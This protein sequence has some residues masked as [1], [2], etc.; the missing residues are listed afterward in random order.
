MDWSAVVAVVE[1]SFAA[2]E[3]VACVVDVVSGV[4]AAV[5]CTAGNFVVV[6]VVVA[7]FAVVADVVVVHPVVVVA[8]HAVHAVVR[9]GHA[10]V[11]AVFDLDLLSSLLLAASFPSFFSLSQSSSEMT[12]LSSTVS[13]GFLGLTSTSFSASSS[14]IHSGGLLSPSD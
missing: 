13:L 3:A 10:Q 12:S 14:C 7:G 1:L 8:Y 11:Y 6:V 9:M 4:A 5:V 2:V